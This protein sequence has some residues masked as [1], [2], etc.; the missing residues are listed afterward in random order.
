MMITGPITHNG[1]AATVGVTRVQ[2]SATSSP[3]VRGVN[4]KSIAGNSG[5]IYVGGSGVT[6]ANGYELSAGQ[7]VLVA[8]AN[9]TQV[10]VI[11][12]TAAQTVCFIGA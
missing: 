9:I 1:L 6:V 11:S 7:S 3:L 5:K 12:D 10:Y 8:A 2:L 4:V